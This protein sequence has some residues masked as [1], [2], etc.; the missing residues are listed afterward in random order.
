MDTSSIYH[1]SL[2]SSLPTETKV[3]SGTPQSQNGTSFNL[4]NSGTL[5]PIKSRDHPEK[6]ALMTPLPWRH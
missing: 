3:E 1:D 4:G 5:A 6:G 2:C